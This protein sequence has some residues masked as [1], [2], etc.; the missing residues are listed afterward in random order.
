VL[1]PYKLAQDQWASIGVDLLQAAKLVLESNLRILVCVESRTPETLHADLVLATKGCLD[2]FGNPDALQPEPAFTGVVDQIGELRILQPFAPARG[3]PVASMPVSDTSEVPTRLTDLMKEAVTRRPYG[4]MVIATPSDFD[5][6]GS[7]T[8]TVLTWP[9]I[10]ASTLSLTDH[11][12]PAVRI[13]PTFDTGPVDVD[14]LSPELSFLPVLPSFEAAYAAGYRRMVIENDHIPERAFEHLHEV[15]I[16]HGVWEKMAFGAFHR[17]ASRRWGNDEAQSYAHL[18]GIFCFN[19]F[20]TIRRRTR[21]SADFEIYD[22]AIP[23]SGLSKRS[24]IRDIADSMREEWI[25]HLS[26]LLR[27]RK[28]T[29]D[30]LEDLRYIKYTHFQEVTADRMS[31][32]RRDQRHRNTT[33]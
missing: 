2:D 33:V 12:G 5:H 27:D 25:D 26:A 13:H 10:I 16:L 24:L 11:A 17:G 30:E 8:V 32:A 20:K 28:I 18:I 4:I 15:C 9:Q 1:G 7:R 22:V 14:P 23:H 19:R 29:S 31:H 21:S 3:M 6:G